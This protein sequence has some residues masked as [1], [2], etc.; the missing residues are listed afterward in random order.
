MGQIEL[1]ILEKTLNCIWWWGFSP[2]ALGNVEHPSIAI[3]P[4]STLT[5]S[6]STY[7]GPLYVSMCQRELYN[8]LT[9]CKQMSD[10]KLNC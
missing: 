10:A 4:R 2:G 7:S 8:H 3:T 5:Q 1:S 6:S 9:V